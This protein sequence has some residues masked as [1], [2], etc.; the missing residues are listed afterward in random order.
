MRKGLLVSL[1]AIAV[2]ILTSAVG[3]NVQKVLKKG[4]DQDNRRAFKSANARPRSAAVNAR[5]Y[6]SPGRLR[7]VVISADDQ[8]ALAEARSSG[9]I[10]ISDYGSFK[11]LAIDD[12]ALEGAENRQSIQSITRSPDH[13]ITR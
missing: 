5:S 6:R 8:T 9:A 13:P 1:L 11:L 10:E 2:F 3:A 7:K 4:G 12:A